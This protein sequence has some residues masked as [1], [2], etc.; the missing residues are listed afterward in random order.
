ME[1]RAR[2]ISL[3]GFEKHLKRLHAVASVAN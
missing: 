2:G 3:K 1:A